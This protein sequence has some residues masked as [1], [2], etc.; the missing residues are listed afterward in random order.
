MQ[1]RNTQSP[2][3]EWIGLDAALQ[4]IGDVS[5]ADEKVNPSLSKGGSGGSAALKHD[6]GY[7]LSEPSAASG[8]LAAKQSGSLQDAQQYMQSVRSVFTE[9]ATGATDKYKVFCLMPS[10][11]DQ[12][13]V[14][15]VRASLAVVHVA[16]FCSNR[17]AA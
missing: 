9:R 13:L 8:E 16:M 7:K 1:F 14:S 3:N 6:D 17:C 10:Q 2:D 5:H 15:A 11:M 12:S 4:R